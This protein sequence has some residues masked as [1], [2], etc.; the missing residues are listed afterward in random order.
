M[1]K[2]KKKNVVSEEESTQV[3]DPSSQLETVQHL[4]KYLAN[5]KNS[6]QDALRQ[7]QKTYA[8]KFRRHTQYPN[9]ILLK[10]DMLKSPMNNKIVQE[11]RGIILDEDKYYQV[12]VMPYA[13]FF[14]LGEQNSAVS[15][16][17]LDF[18][19][20][21]VYDKLD[22]SLCTLYHYNDKW[23]VSSSGVPDG[24]AYLFNAS[25]TNTTTE[26]QKIIDQ[27][28]VRPTS[29]KGD[30]FCDLFWDIWGKLK[31]QL[32][33]DTTKCYMFEML[34]HR[35][36]ILCRPEQE[37]LV[38][39][40]VRDVTT[41]QELH[42]QEIAQKNNWKCVKS[43]DM[44]QSMK[45]VVNST[46]DMNP[47][48]YEGYI[49]CDANF[50]RVKVKSTQYVALSH[51]SVKDKNNVNARMMMDVVRTNEGA[52]F[53]SYFEEYK[54]LYDRVKKHFDEFIHCMKKLVA[55][56]YEKYKKDSVD[57]ERVNEWLSWQVIEYMQQ[58]PSSSKG[59]QI[60]QF[61]IDMLLVHVHERKG[62]HKGLLEF[63]SQC[64][65]HSLYGAVL[66]IN[67][68]VDDQQ[69]KQ[70]EEEVVAAVSK[71]ANDGQ[72]ET[73]EV[74]KKSRRG[75]RGDHSSEDEEE[76]LADIKPKG[77]GRKK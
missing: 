70:V 8:I 10:Y 56:V 13:K 40:G 1:G 9:L 61:F 20:A 72:K 2:T 59:K 75:R 57:K 6:K 50:N 74:K 24:S 26:S 43:Y 63:M 64:D 29:E 11:C 54:P 67:G 3:Q 66:M 58:Y 55:N 31:Y 21:R 49:V 44:F 46:R 33:A 47:M 65:I 52:E 30:L 17:Q 37:D 35:H 62:D 19:T 4:R 42:P 22:G 7:L 14:N 73:K 53:L 41:L 71:K 69:D 36:I 25:K 60:R 27:Q 28:I 38:L 51:L 48:S 77:K 45:D 12:V 18:N 32:P 76:V 68:A 39:H 34:T 5:N 15:T 16:G 23:H